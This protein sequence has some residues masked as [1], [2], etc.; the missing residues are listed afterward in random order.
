MILTHI[1]LPCKDFYYLRLHGIN[2]ILENAGLP[3]LRHT[4]DFR[5]DRFLTQVEHI[6]AL[7]PKS[8]SQLMFMR[9]TDS[10]TQ[11]R[12]QTPPVNHVPRPV[13]IS[14]FQYQDC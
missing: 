1:T 10:C 14:L 3:L 2:A 8:P 7:N 6:R 9:Y 5:M 4:S 13:C 12:V 11:R